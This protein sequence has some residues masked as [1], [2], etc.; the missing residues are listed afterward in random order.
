[1]A[2]DRG[3]FNIAHVAGL[4]RL[5]LTADEQTL[6]QAQLAA[7]LEYA[8]QILA[9]PPDGVQ[10]TAQ[11]DPGVRP[12]RADSVSPSLPASA[13]LRNAPDADDAAALFRVPKVLG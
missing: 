6:Y 2:D 12:P 8:A 5:A 11:A 9:V 3:D 1:M 13:A 7:I 4:A 10:P